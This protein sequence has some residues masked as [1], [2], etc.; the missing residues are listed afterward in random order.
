M[1]NLFVRIAGTAGIFLLVTSLF[2]CSLQATQHAM[3]SPVYT[4]II[5]AGSGG[6]R[7][8]FYKV[9]PGNGGYPQITLLDNSAFKDNG[10]ND[11][12]MTP[13]SGSI[14]VS[15]WAKSGSGLPKDY[16]A[17]GCNI[18][19]ELINGEDVTNGAGGAN[20]VGPCVLQPLLDSMSQAMAKEGIGPGQ[21]RVELFAT[22]GMRT[23]SF[24]NGG[25]KSD[26]EI[27]EF[28]KVMKDYVANVKQFSV[29]EFR[30]SDGNSEEGVWTWINLNDQYYNIFGGN[31]KYSQKIQ[32]PVGDIEVGGS[33]MQ[34]A[35]PVMENITSADNVYS[36]MINGKSF[37]VYSKT[38]LGLGGE[39]MRKFM[40]AA[41]YDSMDGGIS[42]FSS[43]ANAK[44]TVEPSG[45]SLFYDPKIFPSVAGP[46]GNPFIN[47]S[48]SK[49]SVTIESTEFPMIW[50]FQK[51]AWDMKKCEKNYSQ[52][53]DAVIS[54][55]RNALNNSVVAGSYSDL[56]RV[57]E[58]SAAPFVGL[59]G[60][61]YV[62]N[63]L[64][65]SVST[66]FDSKKFTA[67]LDAKC[68]AGITP[69]KGKSDSVVS[70]GLCPGG[71]FMS[72]FLFRDSGLFDQGSK[73]KFVGVK[74]PNDEGGNYILGWP[75]GYLLKK[76]AN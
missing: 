38:F 63:D 50:S 5:D 70:Q 52:I 18:R 62:A 39:D 16:R 73:A 45:I 23:M 14:N 58:T 6:T 26:A 1:R 46:I 34:I 9:I 61:Y 43:T 36:V 51:G 75:R 57:M 19:S 8:S 31:Y 2:G 27:D 49:W 3:L 65:M 30:T 37:A 74:S 44:N 29:G 40:R 11:Y 17:P 59:D 60:F 20:S 35:F 12:L 41:G 56:R 72:N 71:I 7:L 24:R 28:Y 67:A 4:M 55:P 13:S 64:G 69:F 76:Y 15:E 21:V 22:A 33:S 53:I 25:T 47:E 68:K 32:P 66:G 10:I 48:E 54:L 42:C